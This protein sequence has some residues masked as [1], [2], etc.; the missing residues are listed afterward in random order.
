M[1]AKSKSQR[2]L[3]GYAY[4]I[5]KAGKKSEKYK[6]APQ[7]VKDVADSMT[8]KQLEKLAKTKHKKL[9]EFMENS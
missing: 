6:E 3:M 2:R 7:S 1:P 4:A 8:K 9:P 5:K